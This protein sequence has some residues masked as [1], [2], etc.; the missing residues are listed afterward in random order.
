MAR[1]LAPFVESICRR[2]NRLTVR[3]V[4]R[5]IS[6]RACAS[7]FEVE[8]AT[9]GVSSNGRTTVSGAACEG[10]TPSTPASFRLYCSALSTAPSSSGLGRRPLKAE[11][12]G[13]NPVGA[14]TNPQVGSLKLPTFFVFSNPLVTFG[15][16]CLGAF[17][18][19]CAFGSIRVHSDRPERAQPEDY[20]RIFIGPSDEMRV[21]WVHILTYIPSSMDRSGD[22]LRRLRRPPETDFPNARQRG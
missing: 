4:V 18:S 12:T 21:L 16:I 8:Q 6:T 22:G 17:V 14:T 2:M 11:V 20:Q 3:P 5:N 1:A 7:G 15:S 13:S 10:S 9:N 19:E